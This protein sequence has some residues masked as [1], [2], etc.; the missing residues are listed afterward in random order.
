MCQLLRI[1]LHEYYRQQLRYDVGAKLQER[2]V[3]E[4]YLP[5]AVNALPLESQRWIYDI[6]EEN[7]AYMTSAAS[8]SLSIASWTP[9]YWTLTMTGRSDETSLISSPLL[10][11]ASPRATAATALAIARRRGVASRRTA[12]PWRKV[13]PDASQTI[14]VA[15]MA[16]MQTVLNRTF[17]LKMN[18]SKNGCTSSRMFLIL[19]LSIG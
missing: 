15:K 3:F 10:A 7:M 18:I 17:F 2:R 11:V 4:G 12:S 1:Q 19:A 5:I 16:A 14:P 9:G 13:A 8:R 6:I